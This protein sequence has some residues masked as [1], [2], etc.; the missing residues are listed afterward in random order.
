MLK[1]LNRNKNSKVI[2]SSVF[3]DGRIIGIIESGFM[4]GNLIIPQFVLEEMQTMADS[5]DHDKRQK[6]RKGLDVAFKVQKL[7]NAKVLDKEVEAN[8]V[9]MKL[10]ILSKEINAKLLALDVNLNKVAKV[11]LIPV[12]NIND[13]YNAIKPRL[14][15]G[16]TISIKIK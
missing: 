10:V 16:Q 1:F 14:V 15:V 8:T 11:H 13:L 5:K 3:I 7:A 4:E 12:L 2:D 6:G 9:D